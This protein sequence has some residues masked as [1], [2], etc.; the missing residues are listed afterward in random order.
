MI[1]FCTGQPECALLEDRVS[2]V[3]QFERQAQALLDIA[4]TRQPVLPPAVCARTR[5]VVRQVT[6]GVAIGAVVL[7]NC[8]PLSFAEIGPPQIPVAGLS[9]AEVESTEACDSSALLGEHGPPYPQTPPAS[10]RHRRPAVTVAGNKVESAI[11]YAATSGFGAPR[12]PGKAR[13]AGLEQTMIVQCVPRFG[14]GGSAPCL[15]GSRAAR[16]CRGWTRHCP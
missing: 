10:S 16:P 7:S 6:P 15:G 8:A 14:V 5:K 3:P 11:V 2:A 4:E 13:R 1:C 12:R 9:Q